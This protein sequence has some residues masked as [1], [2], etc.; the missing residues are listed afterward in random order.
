MVINAATM[1]ELLANMQLD[2]N[3][4]YEQ[5]QVTLGPWVTEVPNSGAL[6]R[7]PM[8][9]FLATMREWIGPRQF[10]HLLAEYLEVTN[11]DYELSWGIPT[12]DIE[13]D[14]IG[15]LGSVMTQGGRN[16]K[17]NWGKIAT[18]ALTANGNWLDSASFFGDSRT[19][20]ESGTIDNYCT[21]ALS[22]SVFNT[23]YQKMQEY[24]APNGEPMG[25]LPDILMYG[26]K[27]R[28]TA[29]EILHQGPGATAANANEKIVR[30]L[31]N[32]YL[33][34]TYDDYWF[35]MATGGAPPAMGDA[36]MPFVAGGGPPVLLQKRKEGSIVAMDKPTDMTVFLG[37]VAPGVDTGTVPGGVNAYGIH[38]RG[39]AALTNPYWCYAG[40]L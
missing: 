13:D 25:I 28:A 17:A 14:N 34:G 15:Y 23:A 6:G 21:D 35:L 37:S 16:A 31:L 3:Q 36:D 18:A 30:G 9:M 38:H 33:T 11:L 20:G 8:T 12:N 32:P 7:Y 39:A 22:E 29:H 4:A 26:P 40:I 5:T 19:I 24:C 2:F 27:N 1:N 10:G